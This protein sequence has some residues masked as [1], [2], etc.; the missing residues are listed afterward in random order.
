MAVEEFNLAT[1]EKQDQILAN[2]PVSTGFN[3]FD[4]ELQVTSASSN[5]IMGP[6]AT[7]DI[8][9]IIGKGITYGVKIHLDPDWGDRN[10]L[11]LIIDD[12]EVFCG[13]DLGY[14]VYQPF[15]AGNRFSSPSAGS[16]I[17]AFDTPIAFNSSFKIRLR[18]K[19]TSDKTGLRIAWVT[20]LL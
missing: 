2:F 19:H 9:T 8:I 3:P 1:R 15:F 6:N 7:E 12:R 17:F 20:T 18:N 11:S 10:A 5:S 16:N 13:L 4:Y 14:G